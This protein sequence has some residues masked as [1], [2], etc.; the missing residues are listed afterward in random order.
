MELRRYLPAS[1]LVLDLKQKK[2]TSEKIIW[3]EVLAGEKAYNQTG[4]VAPRNL[5]VFNEYPVGIKGPLTTQLE[6]E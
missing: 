2:H 1:K 4:V 6:V 3:K 5:D